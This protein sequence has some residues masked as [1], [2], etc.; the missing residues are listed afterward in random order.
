MPRW[1]CINAIELFI[2]FDWAAKNTFELL[3]IIGDQKYQLRLCSRFNWFDRAGETKFSFQ[4]FSTKKRR[5]TM[6]F[7]IKF[8]RSETGWG[9]EENRS[10]EN[11]VKVENFLS[12]FVSRRLKSTWRDK[13]V[14][15]TSTDP[16]EIVC[17]TCL[18]SSQSKIAS[19]LCFFGHD[20][21]VLFSF[22]FFGF[23]IHFTSHKLLLI[24]VLHQVQNS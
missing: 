20:F 11:W 9:N 24:S 4:H 15:F 1:N 21:D 2:V 19:V 17:Y 5:L 10:V 14:W 22:L 12:C 6:N 7:E 18:V 16:Q 3:R 23:Q 8:G 13:I